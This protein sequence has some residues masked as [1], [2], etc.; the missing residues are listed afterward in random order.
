MLKGFPA[1]F[2][3]EKVVFLHHFSPRNTVALKISE[4]YFDRQPPFHL[5]SAWGGGR[6]KN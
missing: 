4:D 5:L 3:V 1:V 2:P 6:V